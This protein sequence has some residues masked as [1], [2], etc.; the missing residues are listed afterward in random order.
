MA[1]VYDIKIKTVS[2]FVSYNEDQM[3]EIIEKALGEI[4]KPDSNH[5]MLESTEVKVRRIA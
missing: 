1:T 3:Q 2:A 5:P 4:K